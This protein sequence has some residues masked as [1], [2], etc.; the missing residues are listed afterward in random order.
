MDSR[1]KP[2]RASALEMG[3]E[4]HSPVRIHD[5]A[6]QPRMSAATANVPIAVIRAAIFRNVAMKAVNEGSIRPL[7]AIHAGQSGH[8]VSIA[9]SFLRIAPS[10]PQCGG[11]ATPF[12]KKSRRRTLI[13]HNFSVAYLVV[14]GDSVSTV[15]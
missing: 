9:V 10:V 8:I 15:N 5:P 1:S 7:D 13:N 3:N 6:C 11:A 2:A 14:S 12:R 4:L